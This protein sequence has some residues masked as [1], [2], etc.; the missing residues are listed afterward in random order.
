MF[1]HQTWK[2]TRL[3]YY[4]TN[5]NLTLDYRMLE[6]LW[7]PDCYFLNSKDAFVHDVTVENRV[8]QLQ[9]DGTVRYGIRWV[10]PGTWGSPWQPTFF[11]LIIP[12]TYSKGHTEDPTAFQISLSLPPSLSSQSGTFRVSHSHPWLSCP[13]TLPY[14]VASVWNDPFLFPQV[15]SFPILQSLIQM[16]S[17]SRNHLWYSQLEELSLCLS[18]ECIF[19]YLFVSFLSHAVKEGDWSLPL[20]IYSTCRGPKGAQCAYIAYGFVQTECVHTGAPH[21]HIYSIADSHQSPP[22]SLISYKPSLKTSMRHKFS[23]E[24]VSKRELLGYS[25]FSAVLLLNPFVSLFFLHPLS[26]GP[27]H[28]SQRTTK[29]TGNRS[30]VTKGASDD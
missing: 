23:S 11:P 13:H 9:P 15:W 6:K 26:H 28:W 4:E 5:L 19:Y 7:V 25:S 30:L 22:H 8:F 12:W 2:D 14:A 17:L 24:N 21:W 18:I 27:R 16:P 10:P 1:F 29:L 3:A 20:I